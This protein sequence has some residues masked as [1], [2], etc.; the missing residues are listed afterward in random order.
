MNLSFHPPFPGGA[1][2]IGAAG[3]RDQG[4]GSADQGG[5]SRF[6]HVSGQS[7]GIVVGGTDQVV[8]DL[9]SFSGKPFVS[10]A[11]PLTIFV[12]SLELIGYVQW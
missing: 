11:Y 9:W 2:Q 7:G 6:D 5:S 8:G 3:G 1:T 10:H 4:G 12:A